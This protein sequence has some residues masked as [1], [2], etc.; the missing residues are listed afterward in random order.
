MNKTLIIGAGGVG[1]VVVHKCVQNS[2]VF[3][4]IILASRTKARCDEIKS[5]LPN[6]DIVTSSVDADSVDGLIT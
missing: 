2:D 3:G 1:R 4:Q 5:E 6:A